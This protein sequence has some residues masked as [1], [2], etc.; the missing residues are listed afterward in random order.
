MSAAGPSCGGRTL[1]LR[2]VGTE[3]EGRVNDSAN[4]KEGA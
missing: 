2:R 3:K 4:A 1:D